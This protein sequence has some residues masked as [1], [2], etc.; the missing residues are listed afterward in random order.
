MGKIRAKKKALIQKAKPTAWVPPGQA[1][2]V[3]GHLIPDGMIYVGTGV[4]S[5]SRRS[6]EPALIDPALPVEGK[7]GPSLLFPGYWPTYEGVTPGLRGAYLEW[8]ATGRSAPD[9]D[10]VCVLLFFYGIERRLLSD[11]QT[12]RVSDA[13]KLKLIAEVERLVG[14]YRDHPWLPLYAG[15]FLTLTRLLIGD[16]RIEPLEAL[17]GVLREDPLWKVGPALSA[18]AGRPLSPRWAFALWKDWDGARRKEPEL[19][20]PVE[21]RE[22]F[23]IRYRDAFPDGG[24]RL[25]RG[26]DPLRVQYRPVSPGFDRML[27]L[28][29][30]GLHD[31][32]ISPAQIQQLQK[33][34]EGVASALDSYSRRIGRTGDSSSLA[35]LSLLPPELVRSRGGEALRPLTE[36]IEGILAGRGTVLVEWKD[37]LEHWPSDTPG[38]LARRP[39]EAFAS[40][41]GELG[42]GVEPDPRFGDPPPREG[43]FLFR[44]PQG[45]IARVWSPGPAYEAAAVVLQ[46]AVAVATA[47][48]A[49]DPRQEE[50]LLRHLEEAAHLGSSERERLQAR[51]LW[52]LAEPQGL[53]G[54]EKR[55]QALSEAQCRAVARFL[56]TLAGA[57]GQVSAE[58]IQ[59]LKKVYRLLR[60]DPATL[61]SDVHA[62]VAGSPAMPATREPHSEAGLELDLR[63]VEE[64]LAETGQV[65]ALLGEIFQEDELAAP[66][67]RAS[68]GLD[69][70]H[71]AL[72]RELAARPTWTRAE[73]DRRAK[74]LGLLPDG[75]LETLNETAF[76]RC[77]ASLLEGEEM[78][79]LDAEILEELLA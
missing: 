16:H 24:F 55:A 37:L 66:A 36:W 72:L 9:P 63:K 31:I 38:R 8:L 69:A 32:R 57:D 1:V 71:V 56:I 49:I 22:L 50:H 62:V 60:L 51:R 59:R 76:A 18:A 6:T 70:S 33:I 5:A 74:A 46:L 20:C 40:F 43:L 45:E 28:E 61:Y 11:A 14:I 73:F 41:L 17:L 58:E 79:E 15:A 26:R 53:A 48:G 68:A 23:L 78:L 34:A 52:L 67:A 29:A 77:G 39:L 42:Y 54:L 19:R 47:G 30:R 64:K 21:F 25:K 12:A 4:L 35:A 65:A 44:L 2:T 27:V 3:A 10:P 75:A 7:R 13:E